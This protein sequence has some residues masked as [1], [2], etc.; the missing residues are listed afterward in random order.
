MRPYCS[1]SLCRG[2]FI[3][4]II[5]IRHKTENGTTEENRPVPD[6]RRPQ[7]N[8]AT[9][10]VLSEWQ[11]QDQITQQTKLEDPEVGKLTL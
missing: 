5:L 6:H 7:F 4:L 10:H 2:N 9:R 1:L 3:A 8:E 11:V